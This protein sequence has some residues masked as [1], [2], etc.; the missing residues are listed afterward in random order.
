M[1]EE[2]KME[3]VLAETVSILNGIEVPMRYAERIAMP[4][5]QAI[6]NLKSCIE[7]IKDGENNVSD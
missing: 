2:V 6:G 7:A 1:E 5:W 3:D 4:I